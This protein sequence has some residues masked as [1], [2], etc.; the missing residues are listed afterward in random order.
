VLETRAIATLISC[1]RY[2]RRCRYSNIA[3][4]SSMSAELIFVF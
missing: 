4:T 3:S 1:P 2:M